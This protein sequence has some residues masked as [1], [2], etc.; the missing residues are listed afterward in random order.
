[1]RMD[2]LPQ[3]RLC[4]ESYLP[5]GYGLYPHLPKLTPYRQHGYY[6]TYSCW[7][8]LTEE[9]QNTTSSLTYQ[10]RVELSRAAMDTLTSSYDVSQGVIPS[11]YSKRSTVILYSETVYLDLSF[12]ANA[13]LLSAMCLHDLITNKSGYSTTTNAYLTILRQTKLIP[14][15]R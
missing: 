11:K 3:W 6:V 9:Q 10:D 5:Y 15:V 1:M 13:N 2:H 7:S 4:A 8:F 14:L 12:T